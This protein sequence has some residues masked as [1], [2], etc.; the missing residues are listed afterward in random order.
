MEIDPSKSG[1]RNYG[2]ESCRA[3]IS[4]VPSSPEAFARYSAVTS[5]VSRQV[6]G[7]P[8]HQTY[9]S[10]ATRAIVSSGT[11]ELFVFSVIALSATITR[12]FTSLTSRARL[13]SNAV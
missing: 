5:T 1:D 11:L 4:S 2:V 7:D 9:G 6:A 13:T 12:L 10:P 3:R 8:S